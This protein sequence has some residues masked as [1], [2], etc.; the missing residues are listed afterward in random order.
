[1]TEVRH[2]VLTHDGQI[3][4]FSSE[5]A[6]LIAAGAN[7]LPEFADRRMRYLQVS[8]DLE[9]SGE[10]NELKIQTAGA[11]IQFDAEGRLAE[12]TPPA[13]NERISRFEQ[14]TCVQWALRNLALPPVTLH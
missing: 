12:A 7:R 8:W 9:A 5:E 14:D 10:S 1:M 3:R 6:A 4:E 11:A 2:F 13:E